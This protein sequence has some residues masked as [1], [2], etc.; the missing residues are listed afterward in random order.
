MSVSH[1]QPVHDAL[2][3]DKPAAEGDRP[4]VHGMMLGKALAL[5]EAIGRRDAPMPIPEACLTCA[6]RE[7]SMPNMTAGTGIVALNC[8]LRIDP[9]RFACHHGMKEGEPQKLCSG[10]IAAMLAPFSEVKEILA[11]FN[12]ELA[13]IEERPD[14]VRAAFDT[15]LNH[16][17]PERRLDVYQ[18]ARE[19]AKSQASPAS[20]P[21]S[22]TQAD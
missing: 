5:M 21:N 16:A 20:R 15:W 6:F 3:Q 22:N 18:A 17:D 10:Y 2:R 19:Y 8:V 11:A 4:S 9:D 13:E 14:F 1:S 12:H 7:G